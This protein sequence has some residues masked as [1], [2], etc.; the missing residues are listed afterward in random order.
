MKLQ[1][2]LLV[3]KVKKSLATTTQN[4]LPQIAKIKNQTTAL[5]A[6]LQI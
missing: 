1:T 5:K 6:N 4:K 3:K 2:L